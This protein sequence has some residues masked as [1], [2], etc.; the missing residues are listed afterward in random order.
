MAGGLGFC[1]GREHETRHM[2]RVMVLN[3]LIDRRRVFR[4]TNV[5]LLV[6]SEIVDTVFGKSNGLRLRLY[7]LSCHLLRH[8]YGIVP[9][10]NW[11]NFGVSRWRSLR[12]RV[13]VYRSNGDDHGRS[14]RKLKSIA[15]LPIHP[16]NANCAAERV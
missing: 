10:H 1:G 4:N 5:D 2:Q 3:E 9:Y 14:C 12:Y 6:A 15:C 16:R 11:I 13:H 7:G 8:L